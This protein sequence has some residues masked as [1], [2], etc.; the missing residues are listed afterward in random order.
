[1]EDCEVSQNL[2][3]SV[4]IDTITLDVRAVLRSSLYYNGDAH[5]VKAPSARAPRIPPTPRS[6]KCLQKFV[7]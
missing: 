6:R 7:K 1:M 4:Y 5:R 3:L 2:E